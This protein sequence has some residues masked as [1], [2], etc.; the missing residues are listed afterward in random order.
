MS[1]ELTDEQ[2]TILATNKNVQAFISNLYDNNKWYV[3]MVECADGTLYTGISNDVNKRVLTH[4]KGKGAKYTR[5]RLPVSLKWF[6]G[7]ENRSEA[8]KE[9]HRIKKLTRKNKIKL[10]NG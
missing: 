1:K 7:C 3:Y 2:L 8:S 9:E 5:T 4:N 6:S 10:I